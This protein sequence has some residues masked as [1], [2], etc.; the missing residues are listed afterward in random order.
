MGA[1]TIRYVHGTLRAALEDAVREELL[2]KN[3]AKLVRAPAVPKVER[4][5]L[6]IEELRVLFDRNEEIAFGRCSSSSRLLGLRRSEVLALHWSD[7]D[8]E[9]G[10]LQIRHGLHRVNG[11]LADDADEDGQVTSNDPVARDGDRRAPAAS[12]PSK[13]LSGAD[14]R[15]DGLTSV[16]FSR[17]RSERRST[18]TTAPNS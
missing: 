10:T 5:P 3:V 7:V 2:D 11:K 4:Q 1:R 16:S 15:I 14:W 17:H 6:T 13:R 9:S 18:R 8:L 12:E